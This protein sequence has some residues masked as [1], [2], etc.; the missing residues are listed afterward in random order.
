MATP[1]RPGSVST[2]DVFSDPRPTSRS[3]SR[4][5]YSR[6]SEKSLDDNEIGFADTCK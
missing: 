5:M 3:R 6:L 2:T 1:L 4:T